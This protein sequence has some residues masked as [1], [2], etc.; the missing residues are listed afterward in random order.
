MPAKLTT[1]SKAEGT[2]AFHRVVSDTKDES[3]FVNAL[4]EQMREELT[5]MGVTTKE[6]FRDILGKGYA[7]GN[8]KLSFGCYGQGPDNNGTWEV[9]L[10]IMPLVTDEPH[11]DGVVATGE[12]SEGRVI[13]VGNCRILF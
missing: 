4:I 11:E 13:V 2:T 7:I 8:Y 1:I 5:A 6:S 10:C 3:E 12:P 9:I